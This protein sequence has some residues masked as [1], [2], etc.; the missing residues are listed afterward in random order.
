MGATVESR[1]RAA[2]IIAEDQAVLQLFRRDM[3]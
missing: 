1:H 2:A 3:T